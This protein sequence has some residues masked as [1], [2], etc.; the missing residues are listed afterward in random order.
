MTKFSSIDN[1][2]FQ[3]TVKKWIDSD[4]EIYVYVGFWRAGGDDVHILCRSYASFLEILLPLKEKKGAV[5]VLRNPTIKI[6]GIADENL[7]K[8]A[9]SVFPD[10]EDWFLICPDYDSPYNSLGSGDRT[11][12]DMQE[13]FQRYEGRFIVI[14]DDKDFP[15]DEDR[16]DVLVAR[17]NL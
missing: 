16:D 7:L 15:P 17:F 5:T 9:M 14:G 11:H 12:S 6:R 8:Q 2:T 3:S 13:L 4:G 10:G 1:A